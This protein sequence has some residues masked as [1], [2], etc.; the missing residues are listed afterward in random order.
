[1]ALQLDTTS[2]CR[3][4]EKP[5]SALVITAESE[6]YENIIQRWSETGIDALWVVPR[7]LK[8]KIYIYIIIHSSEPGCRTLQC[9][10]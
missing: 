3:P 5:I 9:S 7:L 6:E 8:T 4:K 10:R 2:I 1:M